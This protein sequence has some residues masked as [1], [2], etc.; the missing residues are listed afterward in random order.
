MANARTNEARQRAA[1]PARTAANW[2]GARGRARGLGDCERC[3]V[4]TSFLQ[5]IAGRDVAG[6]RVR[7]GEGQALA[8]EIVDAAVRAVRPDDDHRMVARESIAVR[9]H[10]QGLDLAAGHEPRLRARRGAEA[11]E[12]ELTRL[13]SLDRPRV[14]GGVVHPQLH[15]Q[16]PLHVGQEPLVPGHAIGLV[17]AA[18]H[19]DVEL[20][21][22]SAPVR[23]L[24]L[25]RPKP[26]PAC[27]HRRRTQD[28]GPSGCH[29][30]TPSA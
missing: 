29:R 2:R 24:G 25:S 19:A 28:Q 20:G 7:I 23:P 10:G 17:L 16:R 3:G 9:L 22:A 1:A 4:E 30:V 6:G 27:H 12:L 26:P 13:E 14:V 8:L 21:K 18:D 15:A 5:E 11:G